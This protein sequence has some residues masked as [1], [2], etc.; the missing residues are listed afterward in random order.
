MT[1]A[2]WLD[3]GKSGSTSIPCSVIIDVLLPTYP[4][5][6]TQPTLNVKST[7][8]RTVTNKSRVPIKERRKILDKT[9]KFSLYF[10]HVVKI[11]ILASC[12]PLFHSFIP[13]GTLFWRRTEAA[14]KTKKAVSLKSIKM[15]QFRKL[16]NP[17]V[18]PKST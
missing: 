2:L 1:P 14:R 5:N 12:S 18:M 7:G 8:K 13:L 6:Y 11:R 4:H 17:D 16:L 3:L 15:D 10:Q 9:D